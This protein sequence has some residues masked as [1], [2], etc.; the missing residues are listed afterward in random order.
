MTSRLTPSGIPWNPDDERGYQP[1]EKTV[2]EPDVAPVGEAGVSPNQPE[3]AS[4]G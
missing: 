2:N 3:E 4:S 1:T